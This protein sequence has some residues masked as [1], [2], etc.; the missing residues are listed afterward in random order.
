MTSNVKHHA[1]LDAQILE[2]KAEKALKEQRVFLAGPY[3]DISKPADDH[4]NMGSTAAAARYSVF[5]SLE[6][7]GT[8]VVLGE[9]KRLAELA[10]VEFGAQNN[11]A[12]FERNMIVKNSID[13]VIIFP[14]SPGS[15]L[16]FGDWS[17]IRE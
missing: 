13:A 4:V 14:S 12:I 11:A 5:K 1:F 15:F 7:N 8:L 17:M 10:A 9:H 2:A 16:E 6:K 3:I